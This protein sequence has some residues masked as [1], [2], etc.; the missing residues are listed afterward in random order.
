M[1]AGQM[2]RHL[3]KKIRVSGGKLVFFICFGEVPQA[4]FC[5]IAADK[6]C[7]IFRN[8]LHEGCF[9]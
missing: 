9:L 8:L 4:P 3:R 2:D 5:F 1:Q 6:G 7:V